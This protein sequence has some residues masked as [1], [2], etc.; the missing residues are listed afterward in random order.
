MSRVGNKPINLPAATTV[1][2]DGSMVFVQGPKGKLK[3]EL[4]RRIK[5]EVKDKQIILSRKSD[6]NLD[7]SLHGLSRNLI[8]NMV[9]GV[10]EEFTRELEI[11]GVGYRAQAEGQKL[12][13]QL[14]FSHPVVYSIPE[15]VKIA[16][17][18]PNQIVIKGVDKQKVGSVAAKV[19]SFALPEPYKGKG[20][21]YK[22]EYVRHKVGKAVA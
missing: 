18:K 7:K 15:G 17:P 13:M 21:R 3:Q 5:A 2:I 1:K 8:F 20:I 19:R 14:G 10:N 16:T 12:T 11:R 22:D 9:K 6:S 4:P